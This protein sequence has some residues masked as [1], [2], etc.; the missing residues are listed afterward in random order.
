[1]TKKLY[2][3]NSH[4]KEFKSTVTECYETPNGFAVVLDATAFFPEAGGQAS[5]RGYIDGIEV[6]DVQIENE[7]ILHF[8]ESKCGR[9]Q[10]NYY[11]KIWVILYTPAMLWK[12]S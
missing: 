12:V 1:M 7:K 9:M 2:D 8:T 4:L 11:W 5:D 3:I 6:L 10:M